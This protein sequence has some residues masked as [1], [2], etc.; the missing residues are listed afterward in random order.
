MCIGRTST[1]SFGGNQLEP[2]GG[3]HLDVV[4]HRPANDNVGGAPEVQGRLPY[5]AIRTAWHIVL[6]TSAVGMLAAASCLVGVSQGWR[7]R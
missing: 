7:L 4:P 2:F 6:A 3:S 5:L 1:P